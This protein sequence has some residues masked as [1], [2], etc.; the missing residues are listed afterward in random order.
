[1]AS[2]VA[3]Q[4]GDRLVA[5]WPPRRHD[6]A[7]DHALARILAEL[8][9]RARAPAIVELDGDRH[10]AAAAR[11]PGHGDDQGLRYIVLQSLDRALSPGRSLQRVL[12]ST[13]ALAL[14]AALLF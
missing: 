9:S 8:P 4:H 14:C 11:F 1:T 13:A 12:F 5:L 7:G 10:L 3:I 6:T 2:T